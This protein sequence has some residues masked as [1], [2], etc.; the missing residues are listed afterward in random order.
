MSGGGA[1]NYVWMARDSGCVPAEG[2]PGD[3]V[4]VFDNADNVVEVF[5]CV[6]EADGDVW[7]EFVFWTRGAS[8]RDIH[9]A[10]HVYT[11]NEYLNAPFK[12]TCLTRPPRSD[13]PVRMTSK[14]CSDQD[15]YDIINAYGEIGIYSHGFEFPKRRSPSI[16]QDTPR[17]TSS[18]A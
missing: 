12:C 1:Q 3:L 2:M 15:V 4:L 8:W 9:A 18:L 17:F 13:R 14:T 5:K 6:E 10:A 11:Q 16:D 7:T